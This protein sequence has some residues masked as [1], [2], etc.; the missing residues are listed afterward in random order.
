LCRECFGCS[1]FTYAPEMW[2]MDQP[3]SPASTQGRGNWSKMAAWR[4]A[5]VDPAVLHLLDAGSLDWSR[6]KLG[7][8]VVCTVQVQMKAGIVRRHF[9]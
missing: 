6:E 3:A 7:E 4:R 1:F 2:P 8:F 5:E 9:T